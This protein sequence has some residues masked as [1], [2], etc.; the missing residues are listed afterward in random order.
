MGLACSSSIR[1]KFP[2][3]AS[4]TVRVASAQKQKEKGPDDKSSRSSRGGDEHGVRGRAG[5]RVELGPSYNDTFSRARTWSAKPGAS[6]APG[7]FP[8]R[9]RETAAGELIG[10]RVGTRVLTGGGA[11]FTFGGHASGGRSH[12]GTIIY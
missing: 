4:G 2:A 12:N 3:R 11:R 5:G 10:T 8:A 6:G 9:R 7:A 1:T